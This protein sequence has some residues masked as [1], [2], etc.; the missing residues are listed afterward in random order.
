MDLPPDKTEQVTLGH[1]RAGDTV[2]L[3]GVLRTVCKKDL[4]RDE[5]LGTTLWGDS[6][7]AGRDTIT[8]VT[9]G[10]QVARER[11]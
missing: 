11:V 4:G 5:L 8:R 9:F 3:A 7:R 6:H 1:L 2:L 10:A